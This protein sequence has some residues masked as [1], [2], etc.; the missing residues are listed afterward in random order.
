MRFRSRFAIRCTKAHTQGTWFYVP[1]DE[2]LLSTLTRS[3][4]PDETDSLEY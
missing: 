3:K 1:S 2:A 4:R